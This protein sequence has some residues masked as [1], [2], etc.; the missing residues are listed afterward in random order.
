MGTAQIHQHFKVVAKVIRKLLKPSDQ[1]EINRAFDRKFAADAQWQFGD[2]VN[3][4]I[5][6][7]Q[8]LTIPPRSGLVL[9]LN[10]GYIE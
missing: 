10:Y 6:G 8:P 5:Y 1:P 9:M 3:R 4:C 7:T 2:S